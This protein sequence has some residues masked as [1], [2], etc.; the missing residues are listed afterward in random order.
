MSLT[1]NAEEMAKLLATSTWAVYEHCRRGDFPFEPIRV[2]RLLRWPK[3]AVN[4]AL[5]IDLDSASEAGDRDMHN[6]MDS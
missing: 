3:S 1:Y 4:R 2:G 5:G 6:G